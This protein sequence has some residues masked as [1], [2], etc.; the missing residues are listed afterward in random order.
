MLIVELA[1]VVLSSRDQ[2]F[3]MRSRMLSAF[4]AQ[5]SAILCKNT[6]GTVERFYFNLYR[7]VAVVL[8]NNFERAGN[9]CKNS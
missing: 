1:T 4:A 2:I 8:K 7:F 3:G 5:Y 9:V 6:S